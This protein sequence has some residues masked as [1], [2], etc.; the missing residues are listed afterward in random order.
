MMKAGRAVGYVEDLNLEVKST[1]SS[2]NL[3]FLS[4]LGRI[5]REA[6]TE[7]HHVL[8]WRPARSPDPP[9]ATWTDGG[10]GRKWGKPGNEGSQAAPTMPRWIVCLCYFISEEGNYSFVSWWNR[11]SFHFCENEIN[12]SEASCFKKISCLRISFCQRYWISELLLVV[13]YLCPHSHTAFI[14]GFAFTSWGEESQGFILGPNTEGTCFF[15]RDTASCPWKGWYLLPASP[16]RLRAACRAP[17]GTSGQWPRNKVECLSL[18][19]RI[20]YSD[21]GLETSL[22]C[23]SQW[24]WSISETTITIKYELGIFVPTDV[25]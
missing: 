25:A 10:E 5:Q 9:A 21:L 22:G 20:C 12:N 8:S 13:G 17:L 1:T 15:F 7:L 18:W 16:G 14:T 2:L 6:S 23:L 24:F 19:R 3:N 4:F 11:W